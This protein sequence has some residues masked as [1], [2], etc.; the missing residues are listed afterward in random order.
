M[1]TKTKLQISFGFLILAIFIISGFAIQGVSATQ[2]A[3]ENFV[4]ND[5]CRGSLA[6]DVESAADARAVAA[7]D[8]WLIHPWALG[9]VPE[10]RLPVAVCDAD[11]HARWPWSAARWQFVAARMQALAPV[12]WFG[13]AA[14]LLAA[15]QAARSVQGWN[16]PHLSAAW[17]DLALATPPPAFAEPTPRCRS[18]SA[19]WSRVQILSASSSIQGDLFHE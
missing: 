17:S 12:R 13:T 16:N 9:P 18:F 6:R 15:L 3:F 8:V 5:F 4:S 7:Q 19:Y 14:S 1:Q 2:Q 11:W 10:G